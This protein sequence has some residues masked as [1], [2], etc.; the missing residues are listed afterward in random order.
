ME[1]VD[2]ITR[3]NLLLDDLWGVCNTQ[4][5]RKLCPHNQISFQTQTEQQEEAKNGEK[6]SEFSRWTLDVR[7]DSGQR[8]SFSR[9]FLSKCRC[10]RRSKA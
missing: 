9:S 3:S 8:D 6:V 2:V 7:E 4:I 1:C 10:S 5:M